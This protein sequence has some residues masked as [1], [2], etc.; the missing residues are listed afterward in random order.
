MSKITAYFRGEQGEQGESGYTYIPTF[1]VD[2][3]DGIL[4]VYQYADGPI[5]D[6]DSDGNLNLVVTRSNYGNY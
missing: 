6:L 3:E 5:F 4:Y 1:D 2:L